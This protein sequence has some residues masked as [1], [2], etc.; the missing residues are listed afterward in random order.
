MLAALLRLV[1]LVRAAVGSRAGLAV[2]HP[3]LRQPL[4]AVTRPTPMRPQRRG[5]DQRFWVL[6]RRLRRPRHR[7]GHRPPRA[8]TGPPARIA[9]HP[10]LGGLHQVHQRAA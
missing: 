2:E 1:A 9:A 4:A 3:L 8:A 7:F 6:A 10:V 5:R